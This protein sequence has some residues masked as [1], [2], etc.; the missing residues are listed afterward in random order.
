MGEA[1]SKYGERRG[2]YRFVVGKPDE[3]GIP[4]RKWDDKIKLYLQKMGCGTRTGLIWLRIKT[5]GWHL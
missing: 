3:N 2:V 4:R 5:D 1:C